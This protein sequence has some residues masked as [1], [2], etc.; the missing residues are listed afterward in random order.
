MFVIKVS[1]DLCLEPSVCLKPCGSWTLH[2]R[3]Y[4]PPSVHRILLCVWTCC[5]F[6]STRV[7]MYV[8]SEAVGVDPRSSSVST[9]GKRHQSG[10]TCSF[11][12]S[13]MLKTSPCAWALWVWIPAKC[14]GEGGNSAETDAATS[15]MWMDYF[16]GGPLG[17]L[18]KASP[19]W[20][21]NGVMMKPVLL[22]PSIRWKTVWVDDLGMI[23][24]DWTLSNKSN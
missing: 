3:F 15:I 19:P 22:T 21:A 20:W 14:C 6:R 9:V 16:S 1:L 2:W 18:F 7:C 23:M 11:R 4:F 24:M 13:F 5:A 10:L 8:L 17:K 12:C